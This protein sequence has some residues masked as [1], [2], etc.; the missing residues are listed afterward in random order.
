MLCSKLHYQKGFDLIL[1]SYEN[2]PPPRHDWSG[3]RYPGPHIQSE[4][5]RSAMPVCALAWS[6]PLHTHTPSPI[7]THDLSP[8][9][10]HDPHHPYTPITYHPCTPITHHPYIPITLITL[11][12]P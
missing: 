6:S 9:H 7:H 2:A 12:K 11:T 8:L 1:F 10:T 3:M 4:G 5:S